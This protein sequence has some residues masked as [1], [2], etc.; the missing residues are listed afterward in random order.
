MISAIWG[1]LPDSIKWGLGA[2]VLAIVLLFSWQE[3][4]IDSLNTKL[5]ACQEG[6]KNDKALYDDECKKANE[7]I[8]R[9]NGE[10][11]Q[12][13]FDKEGYE[14]TI[15]E[16]EA[17]LVQSQIKSQQEIA[18]ELSKD[19]SCE[20]QLKITTKLLKDFSNEKR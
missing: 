18:V 8:K 15:K 4:R 17:E 13:K 11:S 10:I 16:K 1:L 20:N 12:F 19:S 14:K 9:Q 6:R 7:T 5:I 3:Y 2:V